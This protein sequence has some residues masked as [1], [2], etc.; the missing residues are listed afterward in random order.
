MIPNFPLTISFKQAAALVNMSTW[1]EGPRSRLKKLERLRAFFRFCERRKW[2]DGNPAADLRAPRVQNRPTMPFTQPEMVKILVAFDKYSK[3]AG[4]ANAQRLKAF[5]LLLRYS[6]MRIG[7][8][9]ACSVDRIDGDRLFLYTQKTGVPVHG[10]LP[11]FVVRELEAGLA[12]AVRATEIVWEALKRERFRSK[13][14]PEFTI[15]L[16]DRPGTLGKLGKLSRI[17][18]IPSREGQGLCASVMDNPDRAKQ[19]L[20]RQRS[21]YTE[22]EVAQV[23]L[24]NR[25]GELGRV[26]SRRGSAKREST[27]TVATGGA[28]PQQAVCSRPECQ[29]RRRADYHRRK[30]EADPEYRQIAHNSQK[31]WREA[32]P[33]YLP[34]YRAQHP[35]AVERN[36]ERQQRR[37]QKRRL[38]W[39]EKNNLALDLKRSAAEV[40]M[41]GPRAAD[42]D[43]NN[44]AS[45]QVFIFERLGSRTAAPT[46]A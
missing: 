11:A 1:K 18:T 45:T 39:L 35:E 15:R 16:E 20:D 23:K 26:A 19:I 29:R 24:A 30:L 43:K 36:R 13:A 37:D 7:D 5:V 17:S 40:W 6:G 33:D 9:V 22:T 8:A 46:R 14:V 25:P 41:V 12:L 42:L 32:H 10:V 2:V 44:L 27:S 3:R 34:H 31:K 38:Q 21:G 28:R 4:V